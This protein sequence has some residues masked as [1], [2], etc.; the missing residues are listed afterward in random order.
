[1]SG[2]EVSRSL[3]ARTLGRWIAKLAA[4]TGLPGAALLV[5]VIAGVVVALAGVGFTATVDAV[6]EGKGSARG[7]RTIERF[8]VQH[9]TAMLTDL[10]RII[11]RL[12][13]VGVVAPLGVAVVLFLAW[14]RHT[15]L[16]FGLVV[17]TGGVAVII[18]IT[19]LLVARSRPPI[20]LQLVS[21][22]GAAFPSGHS[23]ESIACYG[24]LAWIIIQLAPSRLVRVSACVAAGVIAFAVGCSRLYLGVHWA[25]DVVSGWFV[26]IAWLGVTIAGCV[27]ISGLAG[28]ALPSDGGPDRSVAGPLP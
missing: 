12:G 14:R 8:V 21:A 4:R 17:A 23:A 1:M 27:I 19:K 13:G 16:A 10:F 6:I 24:V 20:R 3:Y 15:V 2:P 28:R 18:A 11:T 26:G 22:H 7:D 5:T 25:S 9:R